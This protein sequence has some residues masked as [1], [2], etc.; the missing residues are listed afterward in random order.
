MKNKTTPSQY[1]GF[2]VPILLTTCCLF[3]ADPA[4]AQKKCKD[5]LRPSTIVLEL[6][7]LRVDAENAQSTNSSLAHSLMNAYNKK[8]LAAQNANIDLSE[9]PG[10]V[11]AVRASEEKNIRK[12]EEREQKTREKENDL[13]RWVKISEVPNPKKE[14]SNLEAHPTKNEFIINGYGK[15]YRVD[16]SIGKPK[17]I[18]N[19]SWARYSGNGER[20][21][22]YSHDKYV[23]QVYD[24]ATLKE[25][26]KVKTERDSSLMFGITYDGQKVFT[27]AF[28]SPEFNIWDLSG[29]SAKKSSLKNFEGAMN[30]DASPD[31]KSFLLLGFP[32]ASIV[33][34]KSGKVI[35]DFSN[36]A[37][38]LGKSAYSPDGR[39][40]ALSD[41]DKHIFIYDLI[42]GKVI[43]TLNGLEGQ[44]V[45]LH[46]SP[47]GKFVLA[48]IGEGG[49]FLWNI[50]STN[51][52]ETFKGAVDVTHAV[53]SSD[54][55]KIILASSAHPI[56][57]WGRDEK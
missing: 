41:Y 56:Q 17:A 33:S 45:D 31:G 37:K 1:K 20:L 3:A 22:V 19:G 44:A 8:I 36:L 24:A 21:A 46:F 39:L 7:G 4:H 54:G 51:P 11:E 52:I 27:F 12:N 18:L 32:S 48:A 43:T 28:N 29:S 14:I 53:F 23:L 30:A 6:A 40:V 35:H 15:I 57:V 55:E 10:A 42:Q 16:L 47:D 9:L 49:A 26:Y 34:S 5:I 13:S 2:L 25:L 38:N 50:Q